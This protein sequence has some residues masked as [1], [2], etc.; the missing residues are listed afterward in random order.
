MSPRSVSRMLTLLVFFMAFVCFF[1][2]SQKQMSDAERRMLV[3]EAE[4][5]G[6]GG[7]KRTLS[8]RAQ[9]GTEGC[10]SNL[11]AVESG[12]VFLTAGGYVEREGRLADRD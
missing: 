2:S 8:K 10:S 4:L 1:G 5:T 9:C 7:T 11:I 12:G 3:K 6:K